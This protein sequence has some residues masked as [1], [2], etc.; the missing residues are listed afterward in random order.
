MWTTVWIKRLPGHPLHAGEAVSGPAGEKGG[1]A[2]EG[3]AAARPQ[4]ALQPG[5]LRAAHQ[6][7]AEEAGGGTAGGG[8]HRG[9][10][11]CLQSLLKRGY[12]C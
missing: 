7:G 2:A 5:H 10:V 11:G 4:S 1:E 3:A 12:V 8:E 6:G 9:A